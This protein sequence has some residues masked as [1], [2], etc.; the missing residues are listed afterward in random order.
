M[1]GMSGS[2]LGE[3]V[4]RPEGERGRRGNNICKSKLKTERDSAWLRRRVQEGV[5]DQGKVYGRGPEGEG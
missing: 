1:R 5:M 2:W 4:G 3:A